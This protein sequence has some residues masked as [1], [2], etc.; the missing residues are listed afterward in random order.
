MH[1][2][3]VCQCLQAVVVADNINEIIDPDY[4]ETMMVKVM[5]LLK[6]RVGS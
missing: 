2:E 5:R 4:I 6:T 1:D 3:I